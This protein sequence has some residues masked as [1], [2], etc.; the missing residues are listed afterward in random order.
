VNRSSGTFRAFAAVEHKVF[1]VAFLVL[2]AFFG[3][4]TYAIFN[5]SF[6]D[7]ETV[8]LKSAKAGLQLPDNADV[9]IRGVIVGEVRD[10]VARPEGVDLEL[11]L[12]PDKIDT[13]PANVTAQIIPKTLFGEK[14]V[15]LQ[16]PDAPA[17]DSIEAGDTIEETEVAIEVERV[18]SDIY[19][20]LRTV[21][22]AEINY[23]LTALATALE[24]R[25]ED[26]GENLVVLDDYLKQTNPQIPLLVDDLR[27]LGEV[28]D[29]YR[30]VV[31][32][33]ANLLRNSVTTGRTFIEKQ[34]KIEAFFAD[35]AAF[36][37]T[38]KDF[39]EQNGDNIIRLSE[40][41][42]QQLPVF[43][44]YAPEYPCLLTGIVDV[45]PRQ[46]EAF[47]GYTLH[48][49]LETLPRQPRGYDVRDN[50]QYA[51]RRGPIDLDNCYD[52]I[53]DKYSQSNLPP[54]SLV[55]KLKT[56]VDYPTGKRVAPGF[57]MTSGFAGTAAERSL[58]NSL[59]APA[60]GVSADAVPDVAT[61]LFAPLAR[62]AEVSLR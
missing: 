16:V 24:G 8:T 57:D 49:N 62:G 58:V 17:T 38:S 27:K 36:S 60:L 34:Q 18:L 61:L 4:L 39:L 52:A 3:W 25:G 1:G 32:E 26:I 22:P 19:P 21:Q 20:L 14:F 43:E 46:E 33:I 47:R 53:N 56:G 41:G 50:P 29:V 28:S 2:L 6:T 12:Y 31:P 42:Q 54:M 10:A 11:G 23:T 45:L 55:P 15:A 59:A 40:Q 9:K 35:V 48:I 37:S 44:K 51:D 13:I 30:G 7:Y 5:K